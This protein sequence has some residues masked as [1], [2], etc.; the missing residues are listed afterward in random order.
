MNISNKKA[1][2]L[3]AT[4]LFV[5]AGSQILSQYYPLSDIANGCLVGV[6]LGLMILG[7]II[8]SKNT[9]AQKRQ[10]S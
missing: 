3:L 5:M 10:G 8:R 9:A 4:G 2:I 7:I 1:S 6:S